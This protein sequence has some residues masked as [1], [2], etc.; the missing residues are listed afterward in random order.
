MF[1]GIISRLVQPSE[2]EV[3]EGEKDQPMNTDSPVSEPGTPSPLSDRSLEASVDRSR[4]RFLSP[5]ILRGDKVAD[6]LKEQEATASPLLKK[7]KPGPDNMALS[8]SEF[9]AVMRDMKNSMLTRFDGVDKTISGVQEKLGVLDA[10]VTRNSQK[11]DDHS[12]NIKSNQSRLEVLNGEIMKLKAHPVAQQPPPDAHRHQAGPTNDDYLR[13][14]RTAR[15]WPVAGTSRGE[16]FKSTGHFLHFKLGLPDIAEDQIEEITRPH[17]PSGF[18]VKDEAVV[19][20]REVEVRDSVFGASTKLACCIDT[21]GRPT[22]GLRIEVPRLLKPQFNILRKYG[23]QL[24]N[25]HGQGLR[26]HVKFDD[27]DGSLYLNVKLPGYLHWS[28][29]RSDFAKRGLSILDVA[30]DR[31]MEQRFDVGGDRPRSVSLSGGNAAPMA[32]TSEAARTW[33]GRRTESVST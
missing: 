28:K 24:K 7:A 18:G 14:R 8:S 21:E 19:V 25:R 31:E 23:Q 15:L 26:R 33:T 11:L 29:V 20:F 9:Q 30:N 22:A 13:D 12:A 3:S 27:L 32:Q 10:T 16:L 4:K 17:F 2:G 6:K 1:G 5:G